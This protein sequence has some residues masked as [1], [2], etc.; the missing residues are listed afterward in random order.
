MKKT[1]I[2]TLVAAVAALCAGR[3]DAQIPLYSFEVI[4]PG[5]GPPGPDGFFGLGATVAQEST[6]GVTHLLNSMRYSAG[7]GGFVGARTELVPPTLNNPPGVSSVLLDMFIPEPLPAG[8]TF[9]DMG[10]TIFG[11]DI[12]NAAFGIQSQ[13]TDTVSIAALG[14]GQHNDLQIDLD[15]EFFTGQSFNQIF[16]DD[17]S[18]LDVASAFQFYISKNAGVPLTVYIDNVRLVIPEPGTVAL[19]GL[20]SLGLIGLRRRKG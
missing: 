3:T 9:A 18:D 7:T 13:F 16:G 15:S 1:V 8:L 12:D 5:G 14:P 11:H 10:V 4:A 17:V 19:A 2:L 6:L 20:A